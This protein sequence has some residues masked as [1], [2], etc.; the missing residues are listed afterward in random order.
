MR[1]A[2]VVGVLVLIATAPVAAQD[3]TVG[4]R[5]EPGINHQIGFTV[6]GEPYV[7]GWPD[8][9]VTLYYSSASAWFVMILFDQDS[10]P[11]MTAGGESRFV[12][13]SLTGLF[14]GERYTLWV[15]CDVS[16]ANFRLLIRIGQKGVVLNEGTVSMYGADFDA[17]EWATILDQEAVVNRQLDRMMRR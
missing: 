16:P 5:C 14:S 2:V 4:G 8:L 7:Q 3:S 11:V 6:P 15:G 13:G 12:Q 10:N 1:N 17:G 9:D